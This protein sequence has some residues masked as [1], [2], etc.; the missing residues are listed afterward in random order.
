MKVVVLLTTAS[1]SSDGAQH[2]RVLLP[3]VSV[4]A[5][6]DVT[7]AG[8][9]AAPNG[10]QESVSNA[11]LTFAVSQTEMQ[12]LIFGD[13]DGT[14]TLALLGSGANADPNDPG[15]NAGSLFSR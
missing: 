4:L 9:V 1:G 2:T 7:E 8:V 10:T 6:G 15:V 5:K 11:L 3:S 12:K 13:Q 14:L